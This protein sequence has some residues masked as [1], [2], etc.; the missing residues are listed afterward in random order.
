MLDKTGILN[1]DLVKLANQAEKVFKQQMD[2]ARIAVDNL[3]ESEAK[4]KAKMN[5]ILKSST[6]KNA[7]HEYLMKELNKL[8][9][10]RND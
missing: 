4:M 6:S 2:I 7:N 8:V 10:G 5:A 1:K 9:N 3:P